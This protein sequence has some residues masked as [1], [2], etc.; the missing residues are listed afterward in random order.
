MAAD[1]NTVSMTGNL[2]RDPDVRSTAAGTPV[3]NLRLACNTRRKVGDQWEDKANYFD[4]TV[5]G[6]KAEAC[7]KFLTK[8]QP[9]AVSGRLEWSEFEHD[10][11]RRQKVEIVAENVKFIGGGQDRN[12][13]QGAGKFDA[14]AD[15]TNLDEI[16]F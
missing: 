8:G 10:G 9:V 3:A 7:G 6:G 4:V 5:W 11:I 16:P 15:D 14:P 2:T 12:G 1:L 13:T